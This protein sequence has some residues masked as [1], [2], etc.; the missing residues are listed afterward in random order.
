MTVIVNIL[1]TGSNRPNTKVL[2]VIPQRGDAVVYQ[3]LNYTVKQVHH[4]IDDFKV[5][6]EL[7]QKHD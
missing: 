3:G 4:N 7:E 5:I 6:V 2:S 1:V